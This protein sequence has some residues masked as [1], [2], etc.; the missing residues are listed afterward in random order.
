MGTLN[1]TDGTHTTSISLA[2]S[3]AAAGFSGS[4][5]A[6][7]FVVSSDGHTGTAIGFH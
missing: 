1:L 7:G 5:S 4:L 2:G 6:A 3:F